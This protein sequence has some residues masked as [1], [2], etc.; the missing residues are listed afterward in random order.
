MD[1][2]AYIAIAAAIH[3]SCRITSDLRMTSNLAAFIAFVHYF[4]ARIVGSFTQGPEAQNR[5]L[6]SMWNNKTS[7][8]D[9]P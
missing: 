4:H 3:T 5:P 7:H 1:S 9:H 2:T 8:H 6:L